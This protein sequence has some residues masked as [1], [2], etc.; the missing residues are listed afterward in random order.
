MAKQ[1]INVTL[2]DETMEYLKKICDRDKL[3]MSAVIT[4]MLNE[5]RRKENSTSDIN[6]DELESKLAEL[7]GFFEV[8]KESSGFKK[9][10]SLQHNIVELKQE[11]AVK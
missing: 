2:D 11:P 9:K 1:R 3:T 8:L 4:M 5:K 10:D 6:L 7:N